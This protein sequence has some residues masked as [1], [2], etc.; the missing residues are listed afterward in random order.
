MTEMTQRHLGY[1]LI[2]SVA[3]LG[4]AAWVVHHGRPRAESAGAAVLP[5]L[6]A[7]L[8]EV[9]EVRLSGAGGAHTTIDK[10]AKRWIVR[11]RG[12]PADTGKLRKLLIDLGNLE[13]V[14]RKTRLARNYPILGVEN[15]TSP[16]A[17]GARIDVVTPGKTWSLIVGHSA[18]GNECYVRLVGHKQS[19]LASPLVMVNVKSSQWLAP[20]IV[21]LERSRVS[22][23][24]ER[25]E[26]GPGFVVFRAKTGQSHFTVDGIPRGRKL[27]SP[28]AA[29]DM[30]SALSNL[31]LSDVRQATPPPKDTRFSHARFRTFGGLEIDVEGYQAGKGG[32]HFIEV[33]ASGDGPKAGPE[34]AR[35][36][37][38]VHG[39]AY[40]IPD[41][42][43][44]EIFQ[45][46][47][48]LLAPL[49]QHGKPRK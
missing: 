4:L 6:T 32:K 36:N 28:D 11:E 15:V 5:G 19:L 22:R 43:Y 23:I 13:S 17:S 44:Q 46:I 25:P 21:D 9:T 10:G 39:W 14:A 24:E 41:Y 47:S 16:K 40:R 33:A 38:R 7:A 35:I 37:A 31:T 20:V 27:Q 1:L 34:A 30:A 48:G 26:Q 2:A 12:Y 42:R 3:V 18:D 8:N 49:P 45:P 29:D